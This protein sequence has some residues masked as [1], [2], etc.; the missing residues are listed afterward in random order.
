MLLQF[1]WIIGQGPAINFSNLTRSKTYP[2]ARSEDVAAAFTPSSDARC[3]V[4]EIV[5]N[6][7]GILK[8][9]FFSYSF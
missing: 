7:Y 6:N 5:F 9:H 1:L 4:L 2:L 3:L 8:V